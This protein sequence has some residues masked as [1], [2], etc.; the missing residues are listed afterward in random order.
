M[1]LKLTTI[2]TLLILLS[3]ALMTVSCSKDVYSEDE[4]ELGSTNVD[5]PKPAEANCTLQVRTRA[6]SVG[7]SKISYPVHVYVFGSNGVCVEESVIGSSEIQLVVKLAAGTYDV[8]AVAGAESNDYD[9]PS[10]ENVSPTSVVRLKDG[11]KHSDLMYAHSAVTLAAKEKN[12]LTLP[13]KRRVM[14]LQEVVIKDVPSDVTSVAVSIAPIYE[15]LRIDGNYSDAGGSHNVILVKEGDGSVWRNTSEAYLLE[16]VPGATIK[17]QLTDAVETK[18]YSYSLADEMQANYKIRIEGTYVDHSGISLTGI[19][20]GDVW[21]GERII[22]FDM[23]DSKEGDNTSDTPIVGDAPE[24]GTMYNSCYVLSSETL[25]DNSVKVVL[26]S[27]KHT[28]GLTFTEGDDNSVE[29]AVATAIKEL[30]VDGIS[31]WRLP[32]C[33]E[34]VAVNDNYTKINAVLKTAGGS[35]TITP[36]LSYF[37]KKSD[38]GISSYCADGDVVFNKNTRLR[39]FATVIFK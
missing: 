7:D 36:G 19:I 6:E 4:E 39:A 21:A 26:M 27:A 9:I 10:K 32:S 13:L 34:I 30:A 3:T 2:S 33:D 22:T 38:G 25:S 20:S 29:T 31:G 8:Y 16:A 11:K 15:G 28:Y 37:Y 35:N 1:K 14:L 12:T 18:S 23:D 5:A 17:V 24:A